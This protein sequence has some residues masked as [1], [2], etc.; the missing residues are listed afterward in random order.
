[1]ALL[2]FGLGESRLLFFVGLF[3]VLFL[4]VAIILFLFFLVLDELVML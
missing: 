1:V 2:L 4:I 3:W